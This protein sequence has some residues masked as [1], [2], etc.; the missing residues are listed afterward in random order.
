MFRESHRGQTF[1]LLEYLIQSM[2]YIKILILF[3]SKLVHILLLVKLL[4]LAEGAGAEVRIKGQPMCDAQGLLLKYAHVVDFPCFNS[5]T[6]ITCVFIS[7]TNTSS[8]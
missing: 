4:M 5:S 2:S 1:S 8:I 3:F 7:G 6:E